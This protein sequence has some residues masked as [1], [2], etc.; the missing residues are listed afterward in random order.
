MHPESLKFSRRTALAALAAGGTA[1]A[2]PSTPADAPRTL[3]RWRG[4]N[5]LDFFQALSRRPDATTEDE[6]RWIRDW[7]FNFIRV[8]MDYWLW[9]DSDWSTTRQMRPEDV[10]RIK[11]TTL[12]KIDRIVDLGR[13]FGLHVSLNFHRAPGYCINNGDREPFLLWSDSRAE[14]A[15]V[16]HWDIFA[17]RY[18]GVSE[19]DLS[20]NLVNEAPKPREGYMR[21][22]DYVRVM[23]LATDKIRE[24]SPQRL[25]IIDGLDVGNS[26]VDEMI[27]TGVAQSVHA[28]WPG[29]ISHFR[30]SW[31][32]KNSSFPEPTWPVLKADGTVKMG[33]PQL[34]ERYAPWGALAK[35]GIGVHCGECGCYSKTPHAVFL[36][37]FEDVLSVLS[38]HGIGFSLWN[39]RG[40]FG[41]LD[42]G[43]ADVAYEDWNG[44]K[45]DR[46]LL[47]LMQKY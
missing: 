46:K 5:L 42:S 15:F 8:P 10:T 7:G 1:F 19:G 25:V 37:W 47:S 36:A 34:E 38:G 39:L 40:G 24:T 23:K 31:V 6:L 28:Y 35:Q 13:R 44:R 14:D 33:R 27:P 17:K 43:R 11:E 4:F 18:R 16:N 29:Q 30:A 12:E 45:L 41:V 20:F 26:V 3:P 32:D 9:I 2:R 21:R 22:L